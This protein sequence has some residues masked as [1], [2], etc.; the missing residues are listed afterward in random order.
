MNCEQGKSFFFHFISFRK[1]FSQ[2]TY[3]YR[4]HDFYLQIFTWVHT[5]FGRNLTLVFVYQELSK[6]TQTYDI[7]VPTSDN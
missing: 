1:S 7:L 3:M 6:K 5:T 2:H 4:L